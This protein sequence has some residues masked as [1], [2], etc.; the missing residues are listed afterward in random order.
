MQTFIMI[1]LIWIALIVGFLLGTAWSSL[2]SKNKALESLLGRP[3]SRQWGQ[4]GL[5]E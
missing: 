5:E 4:Q 2:C 1:I 3:E